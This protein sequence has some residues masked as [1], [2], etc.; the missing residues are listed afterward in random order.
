MSRPRKNPDYNPEKIR[1]ELIEL[2]VQLHK[3]DYSYRDIA[4]ELD[5]SVSKV[6][7]LLITGGEYKSD[8]CDQINRLY[9]V[10]KSIQEI[11]TALEVSRA[12]VQAYLPYKKGIYNAKESSMNAERINVFRSR[13]KVVR[14]LV[15]DMSEDRLW[16]AVVA[17]QNYPFHTATGLLFT[18]ELKKGRNGNYNRELIV[19]RRTESKTVVWSSLRLAFKKAIELQGKIVERPKALGDIRGI[20]YIYPMMYRF[21]IIEVPEIIAKKIELR[22]PLP[23]NWIEE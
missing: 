9:E 2:A 1:K 10:G 19:S 7:K 22:R 5:L 6:V 15:A 21:G 18:Y 17:F 11:Q 23:K 4:S 20:S 16:D 13:Q 12:T 14:E 3:K 8:I